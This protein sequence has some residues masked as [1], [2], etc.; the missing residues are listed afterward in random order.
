MHAVRAA[1]RP[2]ERHH[3]F[4]LS[5]LGAAAFFQ[6]YDLNIVAIAL[7]QLRHSFGLSQGDASFW[8][9]L[10]VLGA[11]PAVFLTRFADRRGRRNVLLISILGYTFAT[12]LTALAPTIVIFVLCQFTARLFLGTEEAVVWTMVAEELPAESRGFGF[13]WLAMLVALGTG[14]SAVLYGVVLSPMHLS[15]RWLYVLALPPLVGVARLRRRLPESRRFSRSRRQGALSQRWQDILQSPHRHWLILLC[16]SAVLAGLTTHLVTFGVDF[17]E[18]QRG[19]SATTSSLL[20]VAAGAP[21]LVVLLISGALSDRYGRKLVGCSFASLSVI[22]ALSFFFL[23]RSAWSLFFSLTIVFVGSFG[24]RPALGAFG[25]ELFPTRL[26]ALGGSA[27]SAAAVGGQVLSLELGGLLLR[28]TGSMPDTAA[29]LVLGPVT[30]VIVVAF[31]FPE[32]HGRELEE[33]HGEPPFIPSAADHA[34][35][36]PPVGPVGGPGSLIG[37][38]AGREARSD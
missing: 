28:W 36:V 12:G 10:L 5:V 1:A 26:R 6:G 37:T 9:G 31:F 32:T 11:L 16:L 17:M 35:I 4:L 20:I 29:V 13:G 33:I 19:L 34:P 8:V 25:A 38:P 3:W 22:G 7:P 30:M 27:V 24:A 23:A 15:W 14:T 2:L 21:A 18:T